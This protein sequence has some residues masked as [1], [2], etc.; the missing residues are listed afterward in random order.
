MVAA[1]RAEIAVAFVIREKFSWALASLRRLYALA[2]APFT[3]YF[4]DSVYPSAVRAALEEF[5]AGKDNVV[6]IEAGRFLYSSEALNLV[7]ERIAEPY[8]FLLQN[9]VLIGRHAL[10]SLLETARA[11]DCAVVAP[12]ILDTDTGVPAIH[13]DTAKP[14]AIV[15][16]AGRT[17]VTRT[18]PQERLKGRP[19]VHHFE[20][21]C[22]LMKAETARAV[23]PL[24]PLS[25]HEHIDLAIDLRRLGHAAYLD[26]RARVLYMDTPPLPLR[27]FECP[28]YRFRWDPLR[29]RQ[30]DGYVRS[31]WRLADLFDAMLFVARQHTALRPEAVLTRYESVFE[32]DLWPEEIAAV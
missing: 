32:A 26:D 1:N 18:A 27:D 3:L 17:Y 7:I 4:V 31:K 15:E 13:R 23:A 9:D 11:L 21:H 10:E 24:P 22:M 19:R 29:A 28:Y 2:G 6:R 25:V 16:E 8:L 20:M 5:L 12:V 14:F 30:S